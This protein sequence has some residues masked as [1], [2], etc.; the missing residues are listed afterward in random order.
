MPDLAGC[1]FET[2]MLM[3]NDNE[4]Q[5]LDGKGIKRQSLLF[6]IDLYAHERSF[7]PVWKVMEENRCEN[8]T[9]ST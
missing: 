1:Q 4:S 9:T 2:P 6:Q 8:F 3:L 7:V 5:P